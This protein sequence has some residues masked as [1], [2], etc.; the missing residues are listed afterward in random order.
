MVVWASEFWIVQLGRGWWRW[1]LSGLC[2]Q[3]RIYSMLVCL[4]YNA[5]QWADPRSRFAHRLLRSSPVNSRF[6]VLVF[7]VL[8]LDAPQG[9]G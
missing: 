3:P 8:V 1:Q 2:S 5:R 9:L 7:G 6:G 4:V